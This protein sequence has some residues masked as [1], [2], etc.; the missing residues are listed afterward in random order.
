M[1]NPNTRPYP[2]FRYWLT[3]DFDG[4]VNV[5]TATSLATARQVY[6]NS[7]D[8]T[9]DLDQVIQPAFGGTGSAYV[10]F[11]GPTTLQT[12]TLPTTGGQ[13]VTG[14]AGKVNLTASVTGT[15][16]IANG[17]TNSSTSLN[18]DRF[19]VSSAGAIV[20]APALTD[21]QL[22]I[23]RTGTSP[24]ATTITAGTGIS[25]ANTSGAIT[26]SST[27]SDLQ[28]I[29]D[30]QLVIG[31][32]GQSPVL[33]TLTAG[34][35]ISITNGAGAITVSA[36]ARNYTF[37]SVTTPTLLS[38]SNPGTGLITTQITPLNTSFTTTAANQYA[39]IRLMIN[40][41]CHHDACYLLMIDGVEV[42]SAASTGTRNYGLAVVPF[43]N[44][45][46]S[47]MHNVS[48][49]H[50]QQIASAGSHTLTVHIRGG[51]GLYGTGYSLN[52]TLTDSDSVASERA[53]STVF[54]EVL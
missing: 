48:I 27:D 46:S 13:L 49:T 9:Q 28:P 25:I 51:S 8:G 14:S 38:I 15:L 26:I 29:T 53:A 52:R 45:F 1:S 4:S 12:Y 31:K 3:N 11:T 6:G 19:M 35:G 34:T 18:N 30:G 21:G 5:D 36:L 41:E 42:G 50:M 2:T 24:L 33:A 47:T 54:I 22:Y 20:E 44:D 7:F 10:A 16:P 39:L 17:G 32:T 37:N 23:G 43:D 40:A